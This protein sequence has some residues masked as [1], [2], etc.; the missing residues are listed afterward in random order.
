[1]TVVVAV[2]RVRA[3][4]VLRGVVSAVAMAVTVASAVMTR[5]VATA[6]VAAAVVAAMVGSWG[7]GGGGVSG[8]CGGGG[9][10][11]TIVASHPFVAPTAH[12]EKESCPNTQGA[13]FTHA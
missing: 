11:V 3:V 1:M 7:S 10:T 5:A 8:G 13:S 4:A 9:T 12:L 6:A 2:A